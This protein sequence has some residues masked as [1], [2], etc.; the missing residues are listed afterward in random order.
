MVDKVTKRN[1]VSNT[2]SNGDDDNM[3]L[4]KHAACWCAG[5]LRHTTLTLYYGGAA[6]KGQRQL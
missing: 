3:A 4:D 2:T 6:Q 5:A 1:L